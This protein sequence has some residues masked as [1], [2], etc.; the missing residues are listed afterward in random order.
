MSAAVE[1][2]HTY[3]NFFKKSASF[4]VLPYTL[5]YEA[6]SKQDQPRFINIEALISCAVLTIIPVLPI[7]TLATMGISFIATLVALAISPFAYSV[8]AGIDVVNH[9]SNKSNISFSI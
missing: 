9:L 4:S 8:A 3:W 2:T 1:L 6:I 7:L 5:T